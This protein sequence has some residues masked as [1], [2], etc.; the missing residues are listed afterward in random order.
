[1][2]DDNRVYE[3]LTEICEEVSPKR[4]KRGYVARC[5][6]C[7][8]SQKSKKIR[9]LHVDYYSKYND[10][11]ITCYNGGCSFRSGN[12]YSLYA[13][14]KGITFKEAKKYIDEDVYDSRKI[15]QSLSGSNAPVKENT[16]NISSL[17]LNWSDVIMPNQEVT[18]RFQDRA[19]TL[20]ND[21]IKDRCIPDEYAD[22]IV[23]AVKG[24]YKGRVIIPI[25]INN[26]LVYFQGR[27]LFQNI[28]PKY[29]NPD[30]D[31]EMIISNSDKFS[32]DKYII[33]T[34]GLIDSWMVEDYQGTSVNGGYFSDELI[35]KL[36][37]MTDMGVILVPDNPLIDNAG[38]EELIKYLKEGRYAGK[39]SYY[40]IQDNN[41]KD[42][43]NIRQMHPE[44]NI[45]SHI[46]S[47]KVG[48]FGAEMK[49]SV[50]NW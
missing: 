34:E 45:Y 13:T 40:F 49:L 24:R 29:L 37:T 36:L 1:M 19:Q 47:H 25:Y 3:I 28:E 50:S 2:I 41:A 33:A 11:V 46:I 14:V 39:V 17:D 10:F 12:I 38:R 6:V 42:L 35:E 44:L 26:E 16:L 7:G 30:V 5:P 23:V 27:S 43:N 21:F 48:K 20:L 32:R 15:I 31:K 8:D 9:R 4:S 18:N 22:K